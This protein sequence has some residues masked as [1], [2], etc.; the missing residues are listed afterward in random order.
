MLFIHQKLSTVGNVATLTLQAEECH[1]SA[2]DALHNSQSNRVARPVN[3]WILYRTAKAREL[4]E[5][6]PTSRATQGEISKASQE[7]TFF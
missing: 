5:L 2:P 7:S 6:D 1:L 3:S 4:R